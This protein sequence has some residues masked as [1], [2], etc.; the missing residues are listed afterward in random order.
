MDSQLQPHLWATVKRHFGGLQGHTI[1]LMALDSNCM[2]DLQGRPLPH[3]TPGPSPDTSGVNL[4]A[5]D[6]SSHDAVLARPYVFPPVVLVGPVLRFLRRH[7]RPCTFLALHVYPRRYWWP[8]LQQSAYKSQR[9]DVRGSTQAL[10]TPSKNGWIPHPGL[11][12]DLWAFALGY[13]V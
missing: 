3:Y 12:G 4:F 10:L 9:L 2:L 8:L 1:D 7:N 11:P 6:L 13:Y 5:Q